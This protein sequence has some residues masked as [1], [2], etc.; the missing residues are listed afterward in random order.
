[1][2]EQKKNARVKGNSP[3]GVA[4]YPHLNKPQTKIGDKAV[5]PTYG[6]TLLVDP[7]DEKVQKFVALAT[8]LHKAAFAEAKK[9]TRSLN[10]M[11]LSNIIRE[12]VKKDEDGNEIPTG[13]LELRFKAKAE[14]KRKDGSVWTFK[15]HL[16]DGK[17]VA[18]PA[19]SMIYG[20]SVVEVAFE[21]KH[22][23]M[24]TGAFYTSFDMK[25][26]IVRVLKSQSDRDAS[27]F[28]FQLDPNDA[29]VEESSSDEESTQAGAATA[30]T[31]GSDF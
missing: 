20:G 16:F 31:S 8:S 11:G 4:K 14:G 12:E 10:D 25:A 17:G 15:P 7:A 6:V 1:M 29:P 2:A 13:K 28:G 19:D 3:I 22:T 23:A 21:F 27:S 18:I 30:P 24:Q 9:K 26:V 5:D